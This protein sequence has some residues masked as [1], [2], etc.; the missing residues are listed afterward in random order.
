MKEISSHQFILLSLFLLLS[1]KIFT[2]QPYVYSFSQKDA[3]WSILF[4]AIVD[5]FITLF[6]IFLLQKYKDIS[7]FELL[8]KTFGKIFAKIILCIMF[9]IILF[10]VT[11]LAE[12]TFTFFMKFLYEDLNLAVYIIPMAFVCG[13][14]SVKGIKTISRTIEI[15][16]IFVL[17]G[18]VV[19]TLTAIDGVNFNNILPMFEDGFLPTLKGLAAQIFYRGNGLI[20]LCFMG[21]IEFSKH[22]T[23]KFISAKG[24][25]T[26]LLLFISLIFYLVYGPSVKYIEFTLSGLPQYNPFV[27]DLGRLN[28]LGVVVCVIALILTTCILVYCL[29]L[30]IRWTFNFKRSFLSTS[31]SIGAI[32]TVAYINGFSLLNIQQKLDNSWM[33]V[34]SFC[35][36]IL[37]II[38]I[39]LCFRREKW[40]KH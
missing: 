2:L 25:V 34:A 12:E 32:L 28:W 4:G 5:I 13:Y 16:Y 8:T 36:S 39:I 22:F 17:F 33:I 21:K 31:F 7:F 20:L 10:K 6:V 24:F 26:L 1:T 14:F 38:S 19:C 37:L 40:I 35:L 30:I 23:L 11:F 15:F 3:F 9:V 27:S 29:S 18:I